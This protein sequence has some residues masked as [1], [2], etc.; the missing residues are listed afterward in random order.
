LLLGDGLQDFVEELQPL[1]EASDAEHLLNLDFAKGL[2]VSQE[3]ASYC[4]VPHPVK[5]D[6]L[7]HDRKARIVLLSLGPERDVVDSMLLDFKAQVLNKD[8]LLQLQDFCNV[9]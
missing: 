1:I 4:I 9:S 5:A 2:T 6:G 3:P 7:P 8:E